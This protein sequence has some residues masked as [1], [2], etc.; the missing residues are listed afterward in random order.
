MHKSNA[1]FLLHTHSLVLSL[2]VFLVRTFTPSYKEKAHHT[3]AQHTHAYAHT[4]RLTL[5]L[6]PSSFVSLPSSPSFVLH[7]SFLFDHA[8]PPSSHTHTHAHTHTHT[9]TH[10]V[11]RVL[12][13]A[14]NSPPLL[15]SPGT[16]I[17]IT[18][19]AAG[20]ARG[21]YATLAIP[22]RIANSKKLRALC[23]CLLLLLV[24]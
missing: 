11:V 1:I 4:L 24:V 15:S 6:S 14:D 19:T 23:S 2:C 10:T 3:H 16:I 8:L 20:K 5:S 7:T 17:I 12:S 18:T 13:L 22:M 9:H 21:T